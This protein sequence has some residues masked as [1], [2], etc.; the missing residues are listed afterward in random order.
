M[1]GAVT[2][3]L[4]LYADDSCVLVSGKDR[5]EIESVL[6][7]EMDV[8]SQWLVCNKLSLHL[9][10]TESVLF[11]SK[12]RLKS[13]HNLNVVCNG[14]P[15]AAKD[16]VKYL[17]A[18]LDQCLSFDSMARSIIKK[19]NARLKFL[20]RKSKFLTQHSKRLL[21]TSLIQCHF[22]Y[23]CS[24][25]YNS[26]TKEL[27]NKLQVT[28]NK[29]IR[30]VLGL[31]P[32]AHIDQ[33]HFVKLNWLPVSKRVDQIML[34]YVFKIH[35]GKAPGYLNEHFIPLRLVHNYPTS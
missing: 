35:S 34:C 5:S 7:S 15:I 31:D 20:Y 9:G 13:H 8:L 30:F 33:S 27:R 2:S 28:Q 6:S 23:G 4:L 1:S 17:G 22:D 14:Q 18:I 24:V 25:W 10:K 3:K 16:F 19:G 12:P 11:G 21:A 32:R 26:L 29:M